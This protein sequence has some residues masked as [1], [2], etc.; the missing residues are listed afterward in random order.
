M[1]LEKE[2][3]DPLAYFRS[4]SKYKLSETR[5]ICDN[6]EIVKMLESVKYIVADAGTGFAE[7]SRV[8]ELATTLKSFLRESI[9]TPK[10][11][12]S[13][14]SVKNLSRQSSNLSAST[15]DQMIRNSL[16]DHTRAHFLN[17]VASV[18][19]QT[20]QPSTT[21]ERPMQVHVEQ[22]Q[23]QRREDVYP[24][25]YASLN[26][27]VD[28]LYCRQGY[29]CQDEISIV[30][31]DGIVEKEFQG[32]YDHSFDRMIVS[33]QKQGTDLKNQ[34]A[35]GLGDISSIKP[36]LNVSR[37]SDMYGAEADFSF[38]YALLGTENF[39]AIGPV[40][41]LRSKGLFTIPEAS[42]DDTLFIGGSVSNNSRTMTPQTERTKGNQ[43]SR[44]TDVD[45]NRLDF[46]RSDIPSTFT[47]SGPVTESKEATHYQDRQ[48]LQ[49]DYYG[50]HVQSASVY[51]GWD[52]RYSQSLVGSGQQTRQMPSYLYS[53]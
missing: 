34:S 23:I 15:Q 13:D 17:P 11:E 18:V 50:G 37:S 40:S 51:S 9:T 31:N 39:E 30:T 45:R 29:D 52:Y 10:T 44:V 16:V 28:G 36:S 42:Y 47:N 5:E 32:V 24:T 7:R 3:P 43:G 38:E 20:S 49:L 6:H 25:S 8:F 26:E 33:A 22:P 14:F 19:S 41:D 46:R 35:F 53:K 27:T 21:Q 48:S 12:A 4:E 2:G 1:M